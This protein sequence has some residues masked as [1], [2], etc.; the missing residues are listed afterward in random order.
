MG[1]TYRAECREC[2][3]RFEFDDGGGFFFHLLRCNSCGKPKSMGFEEIGEPHLRY[4]KGLNTPYCM[5]TAGSDRY[6]QENYPGKPLSERGYH[7]AVEKL[8]GDCRCGGAFKFN[9]KARCPKC[10]ST[11]LTKGEVTVDYD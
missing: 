5:T 8:A 1:Q 3:Y 4:I 6:I 7:R 11:K 10:K 2:G 9:A